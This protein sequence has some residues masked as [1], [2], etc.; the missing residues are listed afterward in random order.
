MR[1]PRLCALLLPALTACQSI[2]TEAASSTAPEFGGR[3]FRKICV[4]TP[5]NDLLARRA[6]ESAVAD[7]LAA[8]GVEAVQ[9]GELL[10]PGREYPQEEVRT[11]VQRTGAEGFLTIV[12]RQTWTESH[13]V[14]PTLTTT[15][16]YGW[17]GHP[18]GWGSGS[19]WA[20]GG[21]TVSRPNATFDARLMDVASEQIAWVAS[22]SASGSSGTAWTE[23]RA[24]A[25]RQAVAQLAEDGLIPGPGG[26]A[27]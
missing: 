26:T 23:M 5:E 24:A 18:Y 2:D 1:V 27:R 14:P 4:S 13:Y 17:R 19:A 16:D 10:F 7:A 25:G 20:W 15:W 22:V 6:V 3:T 9:M 21:Y 12:A 8:H 11:A